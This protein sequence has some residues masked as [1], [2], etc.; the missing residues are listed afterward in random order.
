MPQV[1]YA[2]LFLFWASVSLTKRRAPAPKKPHMWIPPFIFPMAGMTGSSFPGSFFDWP[3]ILSRKNRL[4]KSVHIKDMRKRS[5]R[6][7]IENEQPEESGSLRPSSFDDFIG[8][9]DVVKALRIS[10]DACLSRGGVLG[11]VLF[12]GP[13]GLGKTT[14]AGIIAS[15]MGS[16]LITALGPSIERPGDIASL[17]ASAREGDVIFIDEIHRIDVKAQETLFKILEDFQLDIM[18]GK[19]DGQKKTVSLKLPHFTLVGATTRQGLL[20]QPLRD[21]FET[22]LRLE[23]YSR[24]DLG[25]IVK[26]LHKKINDIPMEEDAAS[27]IA[28]CSRGTPR[29]AGR[30]TRKVRDYAQVKGAALITKDLAEEALKVS[31]LWKDGLDKNDKRYLQQLLTGVKGLRTIADTIG[32]DPGTVEDSIEPYLLASGYIEKTASG[33]RITEKGRKLF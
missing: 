13:P 7:Q 1:L 20:Q 19:D 12:Y 15:Y 27:L 5:I 2:Y 25:V 16:R 30:L 33:R 29:I 4:S 8:Q 31:G 9:R 3:A 11:H 26:N 18:I 17:F 24:D 23:P 28:S 10:M 22:I 32:E 21:R 14:L 6:T